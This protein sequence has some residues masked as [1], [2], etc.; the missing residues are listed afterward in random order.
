MST[1]LSQRP[2]W[3][4]DR[5]LDSL[6]GADVRVA[7]R[8]FSPVPWTGRKP[9]RMLPVRDL[10]LPDNSQPAGRPVFFEGRLRHFERQ[11]GVVLLGMAAPASPNWTTE[12]HVFFRGTTVVILRGPAVVELAFPF[13]VEQLPGDAEN[14]WRDLWMPS[15]QFVFPFGD[16][17]SGQR[18]PLPRRR[19]TAIHNGL[20][21]L[22]RPH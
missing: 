2:Q 17:S 21:P 4:I 11:I 15:V 20:A 7:A 13:H 12:G 18:E 6:I 8:A 14:Y 9:P 22:P 5:R 19:A 16:G 10:F 1:E 3:A